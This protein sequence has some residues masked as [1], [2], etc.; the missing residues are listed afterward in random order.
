[1]PEETVARVRRLRGL[2]LPARQ[3]IFDFRSVI[4]QSPVERRAVQREGRHARRMLDHFDGGSVA[5]VHLD[6]IGH[7]IVKDEIDAEDA[8]KAAST[9]EHLAELMHLA[10]EL[11]RWRERDAAA[12]GERGCVQ[13]GD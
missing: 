3:S 13:P 10:A 4:L 12:V 2:T 11:G 7:V 1:P 8:E 6:E 5:W 9:R